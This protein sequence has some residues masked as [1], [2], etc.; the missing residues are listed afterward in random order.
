MQLGLIKVRLIL[1]CLFSMFKCVSTCKISGKESLMHVHIRVI[2][3]IKRSFHTYGQKLGPIEIK[4][5]VKYQ[6][7][8]PHSQHWWRRNCLISWGQRPWPRGTMGWLVGHHKVSSG[9]AAYQQR[10]SCQKTAGIKL[11]MTSP[12][13]AAAQLLKPA[14]QQQLFNY[15]QTAALQ[16]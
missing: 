8:W 7:A 4:W 10:G 2:A 1:C 11:I 15:F 5:E 13:L 12:V 9:A 3:I 6:L 14:A 16:N